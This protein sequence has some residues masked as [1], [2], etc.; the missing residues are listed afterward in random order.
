MRIFE[1]L[2]VKANALSLP[3]SKES[4]KLGLQRPMMENERKLAQ[5]LISEITF[6]N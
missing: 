4:L 2:F 3:T 6:L 1:P 5:K